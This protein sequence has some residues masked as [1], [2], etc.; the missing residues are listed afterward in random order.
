[1]INSKTTQ[2]K[3]Q[4]NLSKLLNLILIISSL[5][6]TLAHADKTDQ[7][8][9][10]TTE[11]KEKTSGPTLSKESHSETK[12]IEAKSSPRISV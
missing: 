12:A 7:T 1:M 3:T 8:K 11:V 6:T 2:I 10:A 9:T 5:F 4:S